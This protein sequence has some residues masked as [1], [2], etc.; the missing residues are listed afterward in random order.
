MSPLE[1]DGYPLRVPESPVAAISVEP[2]TPP[3]VV[4]A[5]LLSAGPVVV[6][7]P[8]TAAPS[9]LVSLV[10]ANS[11]ALLRF[12]LDRG[13]CSTLVRADVVAELQLEVKPFALEGP[14]AVPTQADGMT[15]VRIRGIV[16]L[17]LLVPS[18]QT[19]VRVPSLVV[20]SLFCECL[21]GRNVL[22]VMDK[23]YGNLF[24]YNSH[25]TPSLLSS[26]RLLDFLRT[27]S[28]D[29]LPV[30]LHRKFEVAHT[31]GSLLSRVEGLAS[32]YFLLPRSLLEDSHAIQGVF[33]PASMSGNCQAGS[34]LV[35]AKVCWDGVDTSSEM[36]KVILE[37]PIVG[38]LSPESPLLSIPLDFEIGSFT[39]GRPPIVASL[40]GESVDVTRFSTEP[41][42]IQGLL[43]QSMLTEKQDLS[44][45]HSILSQF[46]M[47]EELPQAGLLASQLTIQVHKGTVPL[48]KRNYPLSVQDSSFAAEQIQTWLRNGTIVPSNSPW[49]SPILVVHHPRTGKPRLCVDYRGLNAKTVGDAYLMPL[50]TDVSNALKGCSV[51]SKLDLVQGFGQLPVEPQSQPFTAFRGVKGGL[52]QFAAC[53]FGLRNV[54][55]VFQRHMDTV[56]GS[57]NWKC[58]SIYI[59]DCVVFSPSVS[60]HHI[61]LAALAALFRKHLIFVRPSKCTFYVSEVEH[62]GFLFD[63]TSMRVLESRVATIRAYPVPKDREDLRRYLGLVGQFRP[64]IP[65]FAELAAPLEGMKHKAS[66][67]PF[68]MSAGS[69]GLSA[70]QAVQTMLLSMIVCTIPD[71]NLPFHA[72]SDAS[73]HAI[74]FILC[75]YQDGVEKIISC[76]SKALDASQIHW[77]VPVKEAFALK[78][79]ITGPCHQYLSAPGPHTIFVDSVAVAALTK[80]T[81]QDS[82]LLRM[83]HDLSSYS[84]NISPIKRSLNKSDI[85]SHPPCVVPDPRLAR[86][87]EANPLASKPGWC[88]SLSSLTVA[89]LSA[90]TL[91]KFSQEVLV[92]AQ[93]DDPILSGLISFIQ[94]GRPAALVGDSF[95]AA[96]IHMSAQCRHMHLLRTGLLVRTLSL[97]G[98]TH[99]QIVIPSS[100]AMREAL[101][102]EAHT[103]A[104]RRQIHACRHGLGMFEYLQL[105]VWWDSMRKDCLS[106]SANCPICAVQKKS[107]QPPSG[108]LH[109]IV[110][111]R[112][113]KV[114]SLDLVPMPLADGYVGFA[115]LTDKFSGLV[116]AKRFRVSPSA[117]AA[118]QLF[119]KLVN[120][121]FCDVEQL[122]VD[123]DPVLTAD[124]FTAAMRKRAI[125]VVP[126][127]TAHQQANFVERK[128]QDTKQVIRTTLHGMS[129]KFWPRVL[130]DVVKFFNCSFNSSRGA[131]PFQILTG[132]CPAGLIPYVSSCDTA[133]AGHV[134]S[135][136][137][138]LWKLV[139]ETLQKAQDTQA[140]AYNVT[141]LD[142]RF[143]VG[144]LVLLKRHGLDT[145]GTNFN[146]Q[147]PYERSPWEVEAVLSEVDLLVRNF[148][149][150]KTSK[151]VHVSDVRRAV[152]DLDPRQAGSDEFIVSRIH[153]HRRVNGQI[154]FLVE[155]EG[156]PLK[157]Q[158]SWVPEADL[159]NVP[160][161]DEYWN[162][163][164]RHF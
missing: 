87:A 134:F 159:Q 104:A 154:E 108:L 90:P 106:W 89:A 130:S 67:T 59:D 72:Y 162:L 93:R 111:E 47:A 139:A 88:G 23:T 57:L 56:L 1:L 115:L 10:D 4:D 97:R 140:A 112:P 101:L 83:A 64:F 11:G 38:V 75:Q 81:L 98:L 66:K 53:P 113:G 44:Q 164:T 22:E 137:E 91:Q 27:S 160:L 119:D 150:D 82:K 70:F 151:E 161:K 135:R 41:A 143:A 14:I 24:V 121:L 145:D 19:H 109:S 118:L 126:V 124:V 60:Q 76:Y 85:L 43:A 68:N 62:L 142:R 51:F 163:A 54:P 35:E 99:T 69:S 6:D 123:R 25:G 20:E 102:H 40:S 114:L 45:A 146:L 3:V 12:T 32:G 26:E 65:N 96:A 9:S 7:A 110:A 77:S 157:Q 125:E 42:V 50:I 2:V 133:V 158:F 39:L 128:V 31:T 152:V 29:S 73:E 52:Y 136:R 36:V 78:H 80:T 147:S 34:A 16:E 86:L 18:T 149:T 138:K 48:A 15:P 95:A 132:W 122:Y 127:Y 107:H 155:W 74:A 28:M 141:H 30:K 8:I 129:N 21:L 120:P 13:S 49:A 131:S 144:D 92:A 17:L 148:E 156:F 5:P 153:E 71:L 100:V 33:S 55:A 63:G 79:F 46:L 84:L 105:K 58:A 116:A 117:E 61:D 37:I 103:S 94:A